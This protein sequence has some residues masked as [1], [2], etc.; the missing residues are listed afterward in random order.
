MSAI[1]THDRMVAAYNEQQARINARRLGED[2]WTGA[3]AARF[4]DDP[5]RTLDPTLASI[6][7]DLQPGDVLVDAGGGAGR[8]S[9]PL[10][11]R[12]REVLNVDPSGGMRQEF[13]SVRNG[14]GIENA[15]YIQA[16]WLDSAGL[17]GDVALAGHVTYFV[18]D[19][20]TFV[21]KLNDVAHRRVFVHVYSMPPPNSGADLFALQHGE[22]QALVPGHEQLLPVLWEMGI[23]PEVRVLPPLR[24]GGSGRNTGLFATRED[25]MASLAPAPL[26][27]A[28]DPDKL[29]ALGAAHFDTLFVQRDGAWCRAPSAD[30]RP[31]LIT[32]ETQP[33]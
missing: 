21:R 12:C 29:R 14:A 1:E 24:L 31:L 4:R 3:L 30:A 23:L 11:L 33:V 8:M 25:A 15:R 9:L 26:D 20:R 22:A 19:I 18:R 28:A 5:H 7:A 13:E 32:W 10:A 17:Q 2:I 6:A 16:D 27:P